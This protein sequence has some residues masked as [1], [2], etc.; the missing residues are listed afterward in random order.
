MQPCTPT[1]KNG[2]FQRPIFGTACG[3]EK[4]PYKPTCR[5]KSGPM[6]VH[7]W[8][9]S[10]AFCARESC[11]PSPSWGRPSPDYRKRIARFAQDIGLQHLETLQSGIPTWE[12]ERFVLGYAPDHPGLSPNCRARDLFNVSSNT[13]RVYT[14]AVALP[15]PAFRIPPYPIEKQ[16]G[17]RQSHEH[18]SRQLRIAWMDYRIYSSCDRRCRED[19]LGELQRF[20]SLD[21]AQLQQQNRWILALKEHPGNLFSR[22][23]GGTEV[24]GFSRSMGSSPSILARRNPNGAG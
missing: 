23:F 12:Y 8:R 3:H 4:M 16:E 6:F 5:I 11:E 19:I 9:L 18:I 24:Y 7:F 14:V 10:T 22:T 21:F 2:R 13:R 20:G 17:I 15:D 1:H